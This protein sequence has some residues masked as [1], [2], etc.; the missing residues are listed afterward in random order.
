MGRHEPAA[1]RE[2]RDFGGT[3]FG[4]SRPDQRGRRRAAAAIAV[5]IIGA[6]G[7]RSG[8]VDGDRG[9]GS[10]DMFRLGMMGVTQ[11]A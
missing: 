7:A 1:S 8:A 4:A 2:G 3:A 11:R 9:E 5:K 10:L 6:L